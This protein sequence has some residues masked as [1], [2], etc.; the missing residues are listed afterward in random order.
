[1]AELG[2]RMGKGH[3]VRDEDHD[4]QHPPGTVAWDYPLVPPADWGWQDLPRADD[5][6]PMPLTVLRGNLDQ[7]PQPYVGTVWIFVGWGLIA[8]SV[9]IVVGGFALLVWWLQ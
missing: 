3:W 7:Q 1:M 5:T 2:R 8:A 6:D 4:D 9:A